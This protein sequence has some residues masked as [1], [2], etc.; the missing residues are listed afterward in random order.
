LLIES[1]AFV[2]FAIFLCGVPANADPEYT[3]GVATYHLFVPSRVAEK[4]RD[5][6]SDD[7]RLIGSPLAGVSNFKLD[8]SDHTY[9]SVKVFAGQNSMGG[10]MA[11]AAESGGVYQGNWYA[12]LIYGAYLQDAS[13]FYDNGIMPPGVI[14]GPKWNLSIIAGGEI[15]YRWKWVRLNLVLTPILELA[16]LSFTW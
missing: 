16:Y 10:V 15:S 14:L 5:K 7:G 6:W 2:A 13:K 1:I 12:G 3:L 4:F 8:P 11:G 9:D